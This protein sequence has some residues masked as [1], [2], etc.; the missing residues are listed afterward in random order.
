MP[1]NRIAVAALLVLAVA[2]CSPLPT[3]TPG[4][5][6]A[7]QPAPATPSRAATPSA[8]AP[9]PTPW[10]SRTLGANEHW[11]ASF[12]GPILPPPDSPAPCAGIGIG[13]PGASAAGLP[14]NGSASDPSL[15]WL[16]DTPSGFRLVWPPGTSVR[17]LATGFEILDSSGTVTYRSGDIINGVCVSGDET[18]WIPTW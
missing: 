4:A 10:P 13:A 1:L 12:P 2:A 16:G 14:L 7:S 3:A 6:S 9:A 15:V 8:S 17:F 18:Y 11:L 5:P